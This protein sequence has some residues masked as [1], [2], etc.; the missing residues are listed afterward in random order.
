M[1]LKLLCSAITNFW[2]GDISFI[3]NQSSCFSC[4]SCLFEG[5]LTWRSNIENH[6]FCHNHFALISLFLL[7]VHHGYCFSLFDLCHIYW[8]LSL[9]LRLTVAFYMDFLYFRKFQL[10]KNDWSFCYRLA[11]LYLV[12]IIYECMYLLKVIRKEFL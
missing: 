7:G 8:L 1:A 3:T 10:L 9:S 5:Y 12:E 11:C 2:L 4:M 6:D